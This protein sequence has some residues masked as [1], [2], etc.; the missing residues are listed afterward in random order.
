MIDKVHKEN[1]K[2]M[3]LQ[4]LNFS[5]N[6]EWLHA[7]CPAS[8]TMDEV[9]RALQVLAHA[10]AQ[11]EVGCSVRGL[12]PACDLEVL[13][14]RDRD[15]DG[16]EPLL[17][18]PIRVESEALRAVGEAIAREMRATGVRAMGLAVAGHGEV[19]VHEPGAREALLLGARATL[20][21]A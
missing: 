6:A 17:A 13:S 8:T 9:L 4:E 15:A 19:C 21:I 14:T 1:F 3:S 18:A 20:L 5:R 2:N 16:H 10:G 7:R 12:F 11:A